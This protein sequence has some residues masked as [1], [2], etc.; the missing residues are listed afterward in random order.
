ME[1]LFHIEKSTILV[2][3]LA[4]IIQK[5]T[6]EIKHLQKIQYRHLKHDFGQHQMGTVTIT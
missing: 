4:E 2:S 3:H 1:C 6:I 5:S